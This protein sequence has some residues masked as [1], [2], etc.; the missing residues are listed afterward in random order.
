MRKEV[1][2]PL[3]ELITQIEPFSLKKQGLL[4]PAERPSA[5]LSINGKQDALVTIEDLYVIS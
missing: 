5:L 3:V 2:R 1:D 4:V